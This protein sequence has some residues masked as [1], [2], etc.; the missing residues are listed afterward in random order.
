[1]SSFLMHTPSAV[2]MHCLKLSSI[3]YFWIVAKIVMKRSLLFCGD[4]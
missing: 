3:D 1:M 2:K 4:I